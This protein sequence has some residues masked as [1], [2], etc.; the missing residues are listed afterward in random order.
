MDG[1]NYFTNKIIN[2]DLY[3]QIIEKYNEGLDIIKDKFI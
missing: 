2:E 3:K 1:K